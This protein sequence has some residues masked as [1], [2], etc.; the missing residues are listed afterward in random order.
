MHVHIPHN[1]GVYVGNGA[2][3]EEVVVVPVAA[4]IAAANISVPVIDAAVIANVRAPIATV[5]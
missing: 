1:C 4:I 5:P 2:V 3:V